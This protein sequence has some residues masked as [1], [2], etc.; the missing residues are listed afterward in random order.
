[1]RKSL[2]KRERIR[3]E[4]DLRSVFAAPQKIRYRGLRLLYTENDLSWNRV[5]FCPVRTF[6][7][8]VDRNRVKR[9]CREIY[10]ALKETVKTG[11]DMAFIIYPG[12]YA[13]FQ[14]LDQVETLLSRAGLKK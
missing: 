13:F 3:K 4:A 12:P 2:T 1:M 6:K 10:R 7:R 14:R 5:A 9:I 8:A 11:Y